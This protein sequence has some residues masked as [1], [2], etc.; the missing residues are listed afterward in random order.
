MGA[1]QG[2]DPA[3]GGG[4]DLGAQDHGDGLG[5]L[6]HARV[7]KADGH[8]GGGR[9]GLY[10]SGDYGAQQQPFD[11]HGGKGPQDPFHPVACQ[12]LQ[13][14]AHGGHSEK[15]ECNSPEEG[16]HIK[17]RHLLSPKIYIYSY[18][19]S[20][21]DIIQENYEQFNSRRGS[22]GVFTAAGGYKR[23]YIADRPR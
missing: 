13:A 19:I 9:G 4:A 5:Q 16:D 23:T 6:H 12:T 15:E 8:D 3:G 1:G 17:Y 18:S 20:I 10:H 7:H 2:E 21:T 11:R 14:G 22:N